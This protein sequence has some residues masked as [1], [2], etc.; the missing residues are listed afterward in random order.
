MSFYEEISAFLFI[1]QNTKC[2]PANSA[3]IPNPVNTKKKK[4]FQ[5]GISMMAH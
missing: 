2:K 1:F 5:P 3:E 4:D